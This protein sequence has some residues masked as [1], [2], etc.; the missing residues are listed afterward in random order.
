ML[1][2]LLEIS[3]GAVYIPNRYGGLALRI[4]DETLR[5]DT[6][7]KVLTENLV[8]CLRVLLTDQRGWNLRNEVCH[9]MLHPERL[10]IAVT[11]RLFHKQVFGQ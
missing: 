1:S 11:D 3:G 9:G 10:G 6:V 4:L 2:H 8:K 7:I 5:K